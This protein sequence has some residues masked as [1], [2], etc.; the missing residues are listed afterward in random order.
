[1][2]KEI[3]DIIVNGLFAITVIC[4]GIAIAVGGKQCKREKPQQKDILDS[5]KIEKKNLEKEVKQLDSIKDAKIVS[6]KELDN[7]STLILFYELI[8]K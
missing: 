1:M 4:I 8:R 7:D 3:E 6:V 2:K 5:I